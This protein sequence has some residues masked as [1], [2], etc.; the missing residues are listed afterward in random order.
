M[1]CEVCG[2]PARPRARFCKRCGSPLPAEAP[3]AEATLQPVLVLVGA[4]VGWSGVG[5]VAS[6]GLEQ[7]ASPVYGLVD[8]AVGA[9]LMLALARRERGAIRALLVRPSL[10]RVN[11]AKTLLAATWVALFVWL[12][13]KALAGLGVPMI[14]YTAPYRAHGYSLALAFVALCVVPPVVEEVA[15]RGFVMTRLE[16]SLRR[17]EALVVQAALFAVVHLLPL[18]FASHFVFGL[19]L[20]QV[21]RWTKSLYPGMLLHALWN[22]AV[23]AGEVL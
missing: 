12:Y 4:L 11:A 6:R 1:E 9:A 16:R 13:F 5:L 10:D 7:P 2:S 15:F 14:G 3:P 17:N 8:L 23:F 20:G 22:T 18:V 19:L 21:R